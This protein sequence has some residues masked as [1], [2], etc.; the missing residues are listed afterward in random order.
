[1]TDTVD[2]RAL[3]RFAVENGAS[4]VLLTAGA[5]P[6]VRVNG[7]LMYTNAETLSPEASKKTVYGVLTDE[8][9]ARF[10][11]EKELDFSLFVKG[12]HR[13]RGNAF[14]Q[15]GCVG[16]AFR[17]I[18]ERVPSREELGLPPVVEDL[19]TGH[20]GLVIVCGP[21][22]HGKSTTQACMLDIINERR[23]LHIITVEDPI[24][25]I[26]GNKKSVVEQREVGDDTTSF[27]SAL[28]HVLRQDPDVVLVGEMRDLETMSAALTAAETGHLVITTLHTNDAVQSVDRLL[29]TFPP[30]Q[31]GQVRTQLAFCLQAVIAQRLVP[32]ADGKGR[33]LAVEILRNVPAVGHLIREGKTHG[34]YTVMET[35]SREGMCTMDASLKRLYMRGLITRSDAQTRMRNPNLLTSGGL[36]PEPTGRGKG[37]S[38][39][40]GKGKG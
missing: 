3:L 33:A 6:V 32:Q 12:V 16:A 25:Y 29:D 24:E 4:D 36:A 28:R 39:S 31:Q 14:L 1:M 8:Q 15:R 19:C 18:P 22:G 38:K 40:K 27:S 37:K 11:A 9:I 23:K 20:Q 10:E 2:I 13:F 5:A 7:D 30:H 26:H 34:I 21:T 17:L 35:Q